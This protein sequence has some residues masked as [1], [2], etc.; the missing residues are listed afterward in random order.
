LQTGKQKENGRY[1][2]APE[3]RRNA[4]LPDRPETPPGQHFHHS[5]L[6]TEKPDKSLNSAMYML[7]SVNFPAA[8][9]E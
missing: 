9:H 8:M 2:P 3:S 1:E 7:R 5:Q 6:H 4:M